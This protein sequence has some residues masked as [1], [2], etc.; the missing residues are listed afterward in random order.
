MAA[1]SLSLSQQQRQIMTLAP[2]LRQSLE[3]LQLPVLELR[4]LIQKEMEQNPTI[5]DVRDPTE[6][7]LEEIQAPAQETEAADAPL[8]GDSDIDNL[9]KLDDSWR[10][11]FLQG[12]EN[13]SSVEDLEERRQYMFDSLR[14]P[15]SLQ[16]HLLDQLPLVELTNEQSQIAELLI[17]HIDDDGYFRSD[18]ET[19]AFQAGS[20]VEE[21]EFVLSKIQELH[22]PGIGARSLSECLTLQL[23]LPAPTPEHE[24]AHQ[25]AAGQLDNLAANRISAIASNLKA[26]IDAVD[27]AIAIIR[28]LDPQPGRAF[29]PDDVEYVEPEVEVVKS[30][31]RYLVKVDNDNL[32]H[33][34]ISTRY[35]RMLEDPNVSAE[36][37]SYVRERIRAG[38]FLIKS[39]HQ[40]QRTIH[41]IATEIVDAQQEFMAKGVTHLKPM[42]MSEVAVKVGVHETTVS[43][44]VANK[45]ITTPHGLFEMKYFFTPGLMTTGG[46][47]V[48]NRTVQD[49]I[50]AMVAAEDPD[51]PLSDQAIQEALQEE[52]IQVARRTV[53]KYRTILKILPSHQRR[54]T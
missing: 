4:A 39:I 54:R 27:D 9:L 15:V 11:Y 17:G 53:A 31:D 51:K 8:D 50:A 36:V 25:I 37:K 19:M 52:G 29:T 45:Y 22:P 49:K 10:D 34:R 16:D 48:S 1:V 28:S 43:R 21:L 12:M 47:T 14:Q 13:A 18:I 35:R 6:I 32:P 30:G 38:V 26:S 44:T 42:T 23:P 46:S 41:R 5:E 40:R 20:S 24:L 33:I 7:P 3:M 2:Q